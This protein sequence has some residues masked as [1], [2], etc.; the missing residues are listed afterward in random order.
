[1]TGSVTAAGACRCREVERLDADDALR[2][3]AHLRLAAA[4]DDGW[5]ASW[6]CPATGVEWLEVHHVAWRREDP[7]TSLL[8]TSAPEP[9]VRTAGAVSPGR[10]AWSP[11]R[12]ATASLSLLLVAAIAA[13]S[14]L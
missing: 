11:A 3:T 7:S 2:Y 5:S 9:R 10:V 12:V 13:G 1:M 14:V 8:R 4:A 6:T